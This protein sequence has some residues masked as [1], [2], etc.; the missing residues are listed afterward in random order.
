MKVQQDPLIRK[1]GLEGFFEDMYPLSDE[2]YQIRVWVKGEGPDC[3]S[4]E[5]TIGD[6][7]DS[8][9]DILEV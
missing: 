7:F 5:S 1:Q 9:R 4:I 8:G 3:C 6:V 2:K